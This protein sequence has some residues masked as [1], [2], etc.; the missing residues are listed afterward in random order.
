MADDDR[1]RKADDELRTAG[2]FLD[3]RPTQELMAGFWPTPGLE[4]S[5]TAS[6][7]EFAEMWRDMRKSVYST[8]VASAVRTTTVDTEIV[9]ADLLGLTRQS[10]GD[11]TGD[12]AQL[13]VHLVI[14]GRGTPMP[15]GDGRS[16]T[17]TPCRSR[18]ASAGYRAASPGADWP[19]QYGAR[20]RNF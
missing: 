16:A 5:G 13:R 17:T 12:G 6:T 18:S 20:S 3:G 19:S 14:P 8:V 9:P 2:T 15:P 1:D 7:G 11:P 4:P 10:G